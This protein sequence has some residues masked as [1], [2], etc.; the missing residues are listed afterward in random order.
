MYFSFALMYE[1]L[2]Y[3]NRIILPCFSFVFTH[4]PTSILIHKILNS[5]IN[6]GYILR[7]ILR[8]GSPKDHFPNIY[9]DVGMTGFRTVVEEEA[10]TLKWRNCVILAEAEGGLA[11]V[12]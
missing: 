7:Y 1:R 8:R 12:V 2:Y 5:Q 11:G 4:V 9:P 10:S 3:N 6:L